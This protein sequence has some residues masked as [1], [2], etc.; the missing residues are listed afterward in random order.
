MIPSIAI[1]G[2]G[3]ALAYS[4]L[5]GPKNIVDVKSSLDN[6]TYRVQDLPRKQDAANMMCKIRQKLEKIV[7][8]YKGDVN[9]KQDEP[10]QRMISRFNPNVLE[11]NDMDADSTS[12]SE[13]KGEKIVVC[14][15][16]KTKK[17]EYPLVEENIVMFVLIHE[18]AH[19]MTAS[20]GHTPE[21]WT[22]FKKLLQDCVKLGVYQ[23]ENYAKYPVEYCG[24]T[25]TDSP[26]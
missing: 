16:D 22:N 20:M 25:I 9:Y 1:A 4:T 11:E 3:L 2:V 10:I 17:P 7:N 8:S 19:L 5:R 23:Q 13:N 26:I 18:M 14:L 12:Y 6:R 15:R 24:M 21:F